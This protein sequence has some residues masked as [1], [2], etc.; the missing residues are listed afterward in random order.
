MYFLL[1]GFA[2]VA[3]TF[4]REQ[5]QGYIGAMHRLAELPLGGVM[6]VALLAGL[7]A[8]SAWKLIQAAFDPEHGGVR[9]CLK[10]LLARLGYLGSAVIQSALIGGAAW[11]LFMAR[12]DTNRGRT[13]A[14]WITWAMQQPFGRWAVASIGIGI[15]VFGL[16]QIYRAATVSIGKRIGLSGGERHQLL[17]A[18]SL[19]GVLTRG[20]VFGLIGVLLVFTAWRFRAERAQGLVAALYALREQSDGPWLLGVVAFGLMAY[21]VFQFAKARYRLI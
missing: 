4:P 7:V 21:G 11:R 2:L 9:F 3:A 20:V 19:F 5:P 13:T 15:A 16:F 17:V 10:R 14:Q 12:G 18:V 6:L 8:F 1:G